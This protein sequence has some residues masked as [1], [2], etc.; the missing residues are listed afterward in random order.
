MIRQKNYPS[1]HKKLWGDAFILAR[2]CW[3]L[4]KP[5]L[6]NNQPP[7]P[8]PNLLVLNKNWVVIPNRQ[9]SESARTSVQKQPGK[10]AAAEMMMELGVK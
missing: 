2:Q 8:W 9:A 4:L 1:I 7:K 5:R 10:N 3:K 6:I